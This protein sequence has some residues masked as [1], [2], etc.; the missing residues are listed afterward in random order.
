[1][2]YIFTLTACLSILFFISISAPSSEDDSANVSS[3]VFCDML[4]KSAVFYLCGDLIDAR[5][6]YYQDQQYL[7]LHEHLDNKTITLL[8][9]ILVPL[10]HSEQP[11]NLD[12]TKIYIRTFDFSE[13]LN[14]LVTPELKQEVSIFNMSAYKSVYIPMY[15]SEDINFMSELK[16]G[17]GI[18]TMF[19]VPVGGNDYFYN[20]GYDLIY[21]KDKP[22]SAIRDSL[23]IKG[24]FYVEDDYLKVA[25]TNMDDILFQLM[26][27]KRPG[28]SFKDINYQGVTYSEDS[29]LLRNA[30]VLSEQ[31]QLFYVKGIGKIF[32]DVVEWLSKDGCVFRAD[33]TLNGAGFT[34][35]P[36]L[37]QYY[38]WSDKEEIQPRM[39]AGL[40]Y[41]YKKP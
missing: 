20:D 35:D 13:P 10:R 14:S 32:F 21:T 11:N 9:G 25:F 3:D 8:N 15:R 39:T 17:D 41:R 37:L 30:V 22:K 34:N 6:Y 29:P 40:C 33:D 5:R 26:V 27:V 19:A 2:R 38:G 12:F 16:K 4:T 31:D 36:V 24:N 18:I 28:E 23:I 7:N 1:M